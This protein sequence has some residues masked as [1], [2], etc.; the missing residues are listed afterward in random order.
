[1]PLLKDP[2]LQAQFDEAGWALLPV[3]LGQQSLAE[4]QE[5]FV[6]LDIR[7]VFDQGYNVGANSDRREARERE[8]RFLNAF[9]FP[10]LVPYLVD[11]L[12]YTATYMIKEPRGSIVWAH[13]DWSYCDETRDDSVM[14]WIPLQDVDA[15]N[16]A[17]GFVHGSHRYFDYPRAFP[18]P[19]AQTPVVQ[20]RLRLI[21][22]T[23]T[24][25]MQ[26]GAAV[27]FNNKTI[28]ASMSNHTDVPRGAV[29]LSLRPAA[30]P[31]WTYYIK[32]DGRADTLLK[33][34]TSPDFFVTYNNPT[35]SGLYAQ[36]RSPEGCRLLEELP[37]RLPQ[38]GWQG[39]KA[40]LESSANTRDPW[41]TAGTEDFYGV[42]LYEA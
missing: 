8:Q 17:L 34:E 39:M 22:Y 19:T 29:S 23:R 38:V 30:Q 15:T 9:V 7:D 35:L 41:K 28:H 14:C 18:V 16:G 13:Q 42:R 33:F 24:V 1:M 36:G 25:P 31:L 10:L 21:P 2:A 20:H 12:P 5:E 3:V 32:P 37:Y 26:A 11:R 6:R 40:L 27:L 4:I